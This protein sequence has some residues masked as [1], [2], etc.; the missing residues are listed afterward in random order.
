MMSL[1]RGVMR[2]MV[3]VTVMLVTYILYLGHHKLDHFLPEERH[4]GIIKRTHHQCPLPKRILIWTT[5]WHEQSFAWERIFFRQVSRQCPVSNCELVYDH[6]LLDSAD[7]VLFHAID[8]PQF[9][10]PPKRILE[11]MWIFFTL[12]APPVELKHL[13][14]VFNWT[15]SYRL[16]SDVPVPY[17]RIIPKSQSS[18][19]TAPPVKDYWANKTKYKMAAWMVSHCGTESRREWFVKELVHFMKVDVFGRCGFKKC[20]KNISLRTLG[21][22]NQDECNAEIEQYMFY[23]AFEN[24]ICQ[25]YI[26]EKFFLALQLDVI[27]VVFGG[28]NYAA[29]APINSYIN[30]LDFKTPKELAKY[31]ELVAENATMYNKY[32]EWKNKYIVELGH[33]F[34]PMVC[35]LCSKLHDPTQFKLSNIT[36]RSGAEAAGVKLSVQ[37]RDNNG[38]YPDIDSWFVKGSSCRIWWSG[39]HDYEKHGNF[40]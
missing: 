4:E 37:G 6:R 26:T 30:A 34:S 15:M 31:L 21:T 32:F 25:D 19:T 17:G 18:I 5:Y 20:G 16:D 27:P 28:G 10:L 9:K 12:E 22:F 13:R 1:S 40:V 33:P 38:S 29:I 11:Q 14:N 24:S 36:K 23:F 8:L 7:A 39:Q 2:V 35:D 3:L